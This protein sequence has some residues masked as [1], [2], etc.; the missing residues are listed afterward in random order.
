MNTAS[1]SSRAT[2]YRS[3]WRWHFYAGL[4]VAPVLLVLALTGAIYLFDDEIDQWWFREL[5]TVA[6]QGT[7]RPLA[8]QEQA[9]QAAYA[10]A[11]LKKYQHPA[12]PTAAAQWSLVTADGRALDVFVDPYRAQVLG[13]V[14]SAW[15]PMSVVS[16]LHGELMVGTVGDWLVEAAAGWTVVLVVTGLYLWWPRRWRWQGVVVP[17]LQ[18]PGRR[19]WRDLHAVPGALNAL[20]IVFLVMSGLPWSGVWGD[21]LASLGTLS[22][23]TDPSPNFRGAP[24]RDAP[25]VVPVAGAVNG[26]GGAG[27]AE[28]SVPAPSAGHAHDQ[29]DTS[30]PW[31]IRHAPV[32]TGTGSGFTLQQVLAL[33]RER[34]V[35]VDTPRLRLF[36]PS[37]EQGVFMVSHVTDRAQ[38]QRTLYIDPR[39]GRVIDDIGWARYSP[40]ARAVEWGVMV[41]LGSQFG[42]ANQLA[43][44][45]VCSLIA[46]A[47]VAGA[48]LWWRR[49]PAGQLG[50]PHAPA[51]ERLPWGLKA[52]LAALAVFFPLV[53]ATL[54]LAWGAD[55][56]LQRR[57]GPLAR[58]ARA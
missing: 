56:A 9:V 6:V 40:L 57:R 34:G 16:R 51:S 26:A 18:H 21:Q 52:T 4:L 32:P 43:G 7:P 20:F 1:P 44:L 2:P 45:A 15:R 35:A 58:R 14:A 30:I 49:R 50:A 39:D 19:R 47:V 46:G 36:Y 24:A 13:E 55:L 12:A 27:A 11:T 29:H 48:V 38:D 42:L 25:T 37:G 10:G 8:E 17:R 41:H 28:G 31:A 3:V 5:N 23:W 33:A 53:G 54:L 22:A